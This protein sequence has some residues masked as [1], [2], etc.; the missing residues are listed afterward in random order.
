MQEAI[1]GLVR[2]ARPG[3]LVV[4]TYSGHGSWIADRDA[5]EPDARDEVLCPYDIAQNRPLTDDVLYDMFADRERGVRI[6]FISDS[7]HSGSV[8]RIAPARR[9]ADAPRVR[10]LPLEHFAPPETVRKAAKQGAY[11]AAGAPRPFGGVLLSGCQDTEYSYDAVFDQRPNGAFTYY[12]LQAL[13]KL[14]PDASYRDWYQAVRT[15]LPNQSQPQTPKFG[16]TRS[17]MDWQ[18]FETERRLTYGD[19]RGAHAG[20]RMQYSHTTATGELSESNR[21]VTMAT[22]AT[23]TKDIEQTI[24]RV[25]SEVLTEVSDELTTDAGET[26]AGEPTPNGAISPAPSSKAARAPA[27]KPPVA[28]APGGADGG[29]AEAPENGAS[30]PPAVLTAVQAVC[31]DLSSEQAG[32]LAA[33]FEAMGRGQS[34]EAEE[35]EE[36]EEEEEEDPQT[37]AFIELATR[38]P[39]ELQAAVD[40]LT[41]T[42]T[43]R[44]TVRSASPR[45]AMSS[46]ASTARRTGR[47]RTCSSR[48]TRMSGVARSTRRAHGFSRSCGQS[49]CG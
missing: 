45:R 37:K 15:S 19:T 21:R 2:E 47:S 24:R 43:R 20:G 12:A 44:T 32:A 46:K 10:F 41:R 40:A 16:G 25:L 18:V 5:D 7:C 4:L 33:M 31:G 38:K 11:R 27:G 22:A 34:G 39:A 28:P 30:I 26:D 36:E 9:G 6:V 23:A 3:D 49:C 1:G 48:P 35:G 14:P 13:D 29:E 42:S 8:S 17:Q